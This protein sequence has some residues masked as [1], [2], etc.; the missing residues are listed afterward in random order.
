MSINDSDALKCYKHDFSANDKETWDNHIFT[1]EHTHQGT[2]Q[3]K[4]CG[5]P[6]IQFSYTG[7]LAPNKIPPVYCEECKK[8]LLSEIAQ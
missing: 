5:T 2:G 3:C 4:D 8:R 7:K 1:V 6:N